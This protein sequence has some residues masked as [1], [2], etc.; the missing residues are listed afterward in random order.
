MTHAKGKGPI[1]PEAS[2]KIMHPESAKALANP[3]VVVKLTRTKNCNHVMYEAKL[4]KDKTGFEETPLSV[5]W[6]KLEHS[7]IQKRRK[8]GE[9]KDRAELNMFESKMAYGFSHSK[10]K[11]GQPVVSLTALSTCPLTMVIEKGVPRAL[12]TL[13][14]P[15]EKKAYE[16]FLTNI[17]AEADEGWTGPTIYYVILDLIIRKTGEKIQGKLT[18]DKEFLGFGD[19]VYA[20]RAKKNQGWT[21]RKPKAS[22]A[23]EEKKVEE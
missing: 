11:Q 5:Y 4:N 8:K 6:L 12:L 20:D 13:K 2:I 14:D 22:A 10:N 18:K 7:Y 1:I 23:A 3:N 15:K 21:F 17:Y 16:V 9:K 19:Y